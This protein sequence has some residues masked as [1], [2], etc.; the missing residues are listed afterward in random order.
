MGHSPT[1]ATWMGGLAL[2]TA[3]SACTPRPSDRAG[4]SGT[5]TVYPTAGWT[6][7]EPSQL[8]VDP[9]KLDGA[10]AYLR[11]HCKDDGL[12]EV[13][14][15]RHGR[16]AWAGDSIDKVHD[17]WSCTKSFTGA[18]A[19]LL[20]EEG[21]I[22]L[23]GLAADDEPVLQ[24]RYS[25]VTYRH[26]LTMTSGY[27]AVG[28]TRWDEVSE[29]WSATPYVPGP[30]LFAPGSA[31]T[32]WDEAMIMAGRTL[33]RA[34]GVSLNDYLDERLFSRIGI[35]KREWWGEGYVGDSVKINF[36]GTGLRM[37][38]SEQARFGLLYLNDGRW[39]GEQLVPAEWVRA[40]TN[41]QV[42][43]S[44]ALGDTDRKS[45]DGRGTYGYNWW[46]IPEGEG[47]P[48]AAYTS[49]LN[50]N[51]CLIVPEWDLVIVRMGVDGN[52]EAGK[53]VV[54]TELLRRL[55]GGMATPR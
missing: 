49:G 40:S 6:Y 31:Y 30:P 2:L 37:S 1:L 25:A 36:G 9:G 42:P 47:H 48:A 43:E 41:N 38:A 52:P 39:N 5:Q 45:T 10:L 3:I 29:D 26:F 55:A 4:A 17:I 23:D 12:E 44:L 13:M 19:G 32:Y 14:V 8:G 24:E 28:S 21:K 46:V 50:H 20:I 27:D 11:S 35:A 22:E 18:A 51:V 54:Y 15:I 33:T 7:A 53:Q 16:V 34:A